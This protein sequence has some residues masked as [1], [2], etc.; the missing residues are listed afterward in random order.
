LVSVSWFQSV[1]VGFD[2]LQL[3][4]IGNYTLYGSA[5]DRAAPRCPPSQKSPELRSFSLLR[6]WSFI[7]AEPYSV[8]LPMQ[9]AELED[10]E[11][12]EKKSWLNSTSVIARIGGDGHR[13]IRRAASWGD[14]Y[15]RVGRKGA[16]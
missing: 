3:A 6:R 2:R 14:Y 16:V 15:L 9:C 5:A 12:D 1:A 13:T 11:F 8:S 10:F 4:S 7:A